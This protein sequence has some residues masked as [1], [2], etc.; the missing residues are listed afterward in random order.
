MRWPFTN[1]LRGA[2]GRDDPSP[3]ASETAAPGGSTPEADDAA[4]PGPAGEL[5]PA[6]WRELP[7]VQR[8]V[9]ETSFTA[10]STAFARSLAG[11][12][13]PD[14]MLAPLAH[15]LT[16]D[17]P[18]GLVSGIAVPL[19]QRL[20]SG[21][22]PRSTPGMPAPA[23][24]DPA[25]SRRRGTVTNVAARPPLAD[26]EGPADDASHD[27][28]P[29]GPGDVAAGSQPESDLPPVAPRVL[30]VARLATPVTAIA[31]ARV[32]D[33][34]APA[35]IVARA[36][37]VAPEAAAGAAATAATTEPAPTTPA[38]PRPPTVTAGLG[39]TG[40]AGPLVGEP[41]AE[42][43]PAQP[44]ADAERGPVVVARRSL[45]ESR[46]LGLGAPL[47]GP[48]PSTVRASDNADMPVARRAFGSAAPS[49]A[50]QP[51]APAPT[52]VAATGQTAALPRLVVARRTVTLPGSGSAPGPAD[53]GRATDLLQASPAAIAAEPS[54]AG[55][56]GDPVEMT[57]SASPGS[58]PPTDG[59]WPPRPLVGE[60]PI[61]VSRRT[62]GDAPA[63]AEAGDAGAIGNAPLALAGLQRVPIDGSASFGK[64]RGGGPAGVAPVQRSPAGD[65]RAGPSQ[66]AGGQPAVRAIPA[67]VPLVAGRTMRPDIPRPV[68]T[69]AHA[70]LADP[71]PVPGR[72]V[73]PV[74][75]VPGGGQGWV[76]GAT[77]GVDRPAPSSAPAEA[78]QREE[79]TTAARATPLAGR[80]SASATAT[81]PALPLMRS[82]VGVAAPAAFPAD[83]AVAGSDDALGW[84]AATGFTTVALQP[85]P[86]VQRAVQIDELAVT[87][88][89][90]GAGGAG[91]ASA[92]SAA[93]P[94]G[95]TGGGG[96]GT[97]YEELAEQV[98]DRIRA[99]L[100]TELVLDRERA[101]MLVDW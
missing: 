39:A 22:D 64:D 77:R 88:A 45:G 71:A 65:T 98:Y 60:L 2:A 26:R 14:P 28:A 63:D 66:P 97:D 38:I 34:T 91:A 23:A 101:G 54:P 27:R 57:G 9:G 70:P 52:V 15:D 1:W 87:A 12:R 89:G 94:A 84:S 50:P 85:G 33:A 76:P 24:G 51:A 86:F 100:V 78:I 68:S 37:P 79:R 35:P 6:A 75:A 32:A 40:S 69:L 92:G 30:P 31:A 42:T 81:A 72:L 11:R 29:S 13:V 55:G 17:G 90:D 36:L 19:V 80:G 96:E 18:A 7:P 49:P 25:R 43:G 61:T 47:A 59:S 62:L 16:A 73:I 99:R 95:S 58:E 48:P 8:A 21:A 93:G 4:G 10:P 56:P 53:P 41:A 74:P 5:R 83:P 44:G 46:R 67:T 3:G 82:S 20:P